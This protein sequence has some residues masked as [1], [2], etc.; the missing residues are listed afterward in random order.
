MMKLTMAILSVSLLLTTSSAKDCVDI[1]GTW[2]YVTQEKRTKKGILTFTYKTDHY[3]YE[4]EEF[5]KY[6]FKTGAHFGAT[7]RC[8]EKQKYR[9][10]IGTSPKCTLEKFT[11]TD[12]FWNCGKYGTITYTKK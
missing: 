9:R 7:D 11:K 1:E 6:T 5:G 10:Q 8:I 4:Q 3:S 12:M 2:D